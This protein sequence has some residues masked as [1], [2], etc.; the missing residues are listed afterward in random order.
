MSSRPALPAL[1]TLLALPELL[2]QPAL[3]KPPKLPPVAENTQFKSVKLVEKTVGKMVKHKIRLNI[4]VLIYK[5]DLSR[6]L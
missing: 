2:E 3:P 6:P 1:P 4:I 5:A